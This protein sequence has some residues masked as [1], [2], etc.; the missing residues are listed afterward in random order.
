[1]KREMDQ[2]CVRAEAAERKLET[3]EKKRFECRV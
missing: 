1:M 3:A 2:A